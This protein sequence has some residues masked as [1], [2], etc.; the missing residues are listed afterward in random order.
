MPL[1][2]IK[3]DA[4]GE[5]QEIYRSLSEIDRLPECCGVKM[6]RI[7]SAPM[8]MNDID[9]Y[10]SMITGEM[11]MSRSQHRTHLKDH[12]CIEVGNEIQK[13]KPATPPA[14]LKEKLTEAVYKRS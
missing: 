5:T 13:S 11:I 6:H 8:V 4:C 3:C 7:L 10:R 12:N 14:G 9:P 2:D 1:Y